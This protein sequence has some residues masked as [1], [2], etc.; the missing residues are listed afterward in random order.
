MKRDDGG[1]GGWVI[2][3]VVLKLAI[4]G[5]KVVAGNGRVDGL[6]DGCGAGGG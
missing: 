5:I 4:I 2:M 1:G 6:R 3:G